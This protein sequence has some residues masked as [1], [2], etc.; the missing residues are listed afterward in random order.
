[1]L[2]RVYSLSSSKE[3]KLVQKTGETFSSPNFIIKFINHN[4]DAKPRFAFVISTN[5][6]KL[7]ADRNKVK[8]CLA[9]GARHTLG[10]IKPGIDIV[11]IAKPGSER[12]Y[13]ADLMHEV[14]DA[15]EQAGLLK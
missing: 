3:I 11:F 8:R 9:E 10:F 15:F 12:K 13:Q 14:K 1:M 4:T 5:V 2:A 6:S 7:A